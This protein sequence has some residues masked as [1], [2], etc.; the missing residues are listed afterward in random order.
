MGFPRK[1]AG[2]VVVRI[3]D[4]IAL[5]VCVCWGGGREEMEGGREQKEQRHVRLVCDFVYT[6]MYVQFQYVPVTIIIIFYI[7]HVICMHK[8]NMFY[9]F[10]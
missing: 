7:K 10:T 5:C 2:S 9:V 6:Y 8:I 3:D 4:A 1:S